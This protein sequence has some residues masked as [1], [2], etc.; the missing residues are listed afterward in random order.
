MPT[1]PTEARTDTVTTL[2][3]EHPVRGRAPLLLNHEQWA[4]K[5]ALEYM[6]STVKANFA[7][8]DD[9]L[10][11]RYITLQRKAVAALQAVETENTR[12]RDT[13][14]AT[15]LSALKRELKTLTG[16]DI[17]PESAR[18][19]TRYRA[20]KEGR[21]PLDVLTGTV[22]PEPKLSLNPTRVPRALDESQYVDS[23]HS[24]TLWDAACANFGYATDSVLLKPFS[25]EQASFI[26]YGE[27]A[28]EH[29]V[30]PY[31]AIVRRLDIGSALARTLSTE[32]GDTGTLKGLVR[33]ASRANFEFEL[34]EAHRNAAVSGIDRAAYELLL[35]VLKHEISA[36]IRPMMMLREPRAIIPSSIATPLLFIKLWNDE[37]TYSYFPQRLGGA[38]R[39]H[40]DGRDALPHFKQ[41]L[42]EDQRKKQ[43]GW[44]AR[45]WPLHELAHFQK[46]LTEEPRPKGLNPLAGLL[47][48]GFHAAFP[49]PSLENLTF[50][51]QPPENGRPTL[52]D[53]LAERQQSR[54]LANLSHLATT[55]SAADW[56][57]F[58]DQASAIGNEV[59]SMLTT[60][61]PGGVMGLNRIMQVAIFGS[62]AYSV[63]QGV[64]EAS[65]GDA[66]NFAGA[67]AD[68]V[69][70][71]ISGFLVGRASKIHRQRMHTL[72]NRT[73]KLRKV[74]R[75]DGAPELWAPDL[76]VYPRLEA[77]AMAGLTPT[78]DG[79]YERDG[80]YFA[81]V[82]DGETLRVLE[83]IQD[84]A[85]RG[86][87]LKPREAGAFAAPVTFDRA[88]STWRLA[89]DDVRGLSDVQL[90]DR[91]LAVD[92]P[93]QSPADLKRVL[94]ITGTTREQ[95]QN[96]WHGELI[97]GPLADG[98]RRLQTDR[99][100]DQ[101][102]SDVPLRG[103]MPLNADGAV[104]ALLTRLESWPAATVLDVYNPQGELTHTYGPDY[105]P[106]VMVNRV[107]LKRLEHGGYVA[108]DDVTQ[109]EGGAEQMFSLI[110]KQQPAGSR[111]G[112]TS[113]RVLS[114]TGRIA[115]VREHIADLAKTDRGLLFKALTALDGHTRNDPVASADPAKQYLPLSCPSI[116]DST[117]PLLA[118]LHEINPSLS[119]E[120]L[121]P[122]LAAH[123]F[124]PYQVTRAMGPDNAQPLAFAS[125]VDQL[126]IKLRVD[127]ALDGIYHTRAYGRDADHWALE[128]ARGVFHDTLQRDLVVT[129]ESTAAPGHYYDPK[130]P[131]DTT[132]E[133]V[134]YGSGKY[135]SRNFQNGSLEG[136]GLGPDQ[137]YQSINARLQPRERTR[138]GMKD[139]TDIAALRQ[140]VGDAMLA[141]RQPDGLVNLWDTSNGQYERD[142]TL[143]HNKTPGELGLYEVGGYLYVTLYGAVYQVQF[144]ATRHK[145]R[146]KHPDKV[147]V[148]TPTLEHNGDG[149]WRQSS[150]NPLDWG[151]IQLL[152]R[153]RAERVTVSEKMGQQ[154]MAVS[155]AD[156]GVLRQVHANN[157]KPPPILMDTWSR[158]EIESEIQHFVTR[159]QAHHTLPYANGDLQL[160][161][162][163]SVPGWPRGKVLKVVDQ[164]GTTMKEYGPD[165][166]AGL[167]RISLSIDQVR[168]GKFLH[169]VLTRMNEAE[170]R[171]LLGD[172]DPSIEVRVLGLAKKLAANALKREAN[173]FKAMYERAQSTS[174]PHVLLVQKQYSEMPRRVIE[175]LL[176]YTTAHEQ[177]HFLD[178]GLIP[179]RMS[180]Q[181][182]WTAREVRLA[183][184]YEGLYLDAAASPDS[185]KMTLHLLPALAGWPG[186]ISIEV[187]RH[188]VNGPVI[189]RV[190]PEQGVNTRVLVK[191]DNRYRAYSQQG[192]ALN[193]ESTTHNNLLSSILH[194]LSEA[195]RVAIA[196]A[197]VGDTA[198]LAE[199]IR[200]QA[201]KQRSTMRNLLALQAPAPWKKP[202]MRVDSSFIAY[203]LVV[204]YQHSV[205]SLDLVRQVRRLYPALS[206]DG[207]IRFLDELGG[208]E[209]SRSQE[210]ATR[211]VQFETLQAELTRWE[212]NTTY[213][214]TA[215]NTAASSAVHRHFVRFNIES[216]WRRETPVIADDHGVPLGHLLDLSFQ[217]VGDLPAL[218][219]DFSHV[220][221]V[222]MTGMNLHS[223]SEAFLSRFTGLRRLFMTQNHLTSLPVA[224][225]TMA[226]LNV[227]GLSG[228]QIALTPESVQRLAG[229]VQL[230]A[231]FMDN[232]PLGLAPDVTGM[233][234]LRELRL[235]N[236]GISEWP[237]GLTGLNRVSTVDLRSNQIRT[238]PQAVFNA[239]EPA[240]TNRGTW[241]QGNP[242][243]AQSHR[244]L[245]E[246]RLRTHINMGIMPVRVH[247]STAELRQQHQRLTAIDPWLSRTLTPGQ[248][249]LKLEQW[250]MIGQLGS[251]ALH[252]KVMLK[253]LA[254]AQRTMSEPEQARLKERVW[255]MI[256]SVL[257]DTTL[258]EKLMKTEYE[259]TCED[260]VMVQFVDRE[261]MVL[262]HEFEQRT[263]A[264]QRE[265]DYF[266]F[267][268]M[269]FRLKQ[270][271]LQ[272]Q[273]AIADLY[274]QRLQELD[275][276]SADEGV[277]GGEALPSV[278]GY[279]VALHYRVRLADSLELP[280]YTEK[281]LY[282]SEV[283]LT[284]ADV[285]R[286]KALIIEKESLPEFR[287]SLSRQPFWLDYLKTRFADQFEAIEAKY[288]QD[289]L[290]LSEEVG[291]TEEVELQRG[292]QLTQDRDQRIQLLIE[293]LTQQA[294]HAAQGQAMDVT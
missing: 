281:P 289:Y 133:L 294:Q 223:G 53:C 156:E 164:Y 255:S 230:N 141:R 38:V 2:P 8:L 195:E 58:K 200:E 203:P 242:L 114:D 75:E 95:L 162:L 288:Q 32:M 128:F 1:R 26:R 65:K 23:L 45:Q 251:E 154:I 112:Q 210:L 44:F 101:I 16:F 243:S 207:I 181:F 201:I 9:E 269:L 72:W 134:S 185:E 250:N 77:E 17:D 179:P 233:T 130:G 6:A 60:P 35:S 124:T 271:D 55:R 13:F 232:N 144:D 4:Q 257:A 261:L 21:S 247:E 93:T 172:Y 161:L 188:D 258:R 79:V 224:I 76:S 70:M 280:I 198:T 97:P 175:H 256:G 236:A 277:G 123:P 225:A 139:D 158:F 136:P 178:Q 174:R 264:S 88:S 39:Y 92:R 85:G 165:L 5:E 96:T 282:A 268:R 54:Y 167:A 73:G 193:L 176:D 270:V 18:I 285:A 109:G 37:G 49:E 221:V 64:I 34:L 132:V 205:H 131:D 12:I 43:L 222:N 211:R 78:A 33:E 266:S 137:L 231:L 197:D 22:E 46:L 245:S 135:K 215:G 81:K 168:S 84:S 204:E 199:K 147:G 74:T 276:Q 105:S 212:I 48:D 216:A 36:D 94:D 63:V 52:V 182:T 190:G 82:Q 41:Q 27:P 146:L 278:D 262:T 86:F 229:C 267:A 239:P 117:A 192:V 11:K 177:T 152:R 184:A 291:L 191:H 208:T 155:N 287:F 157:L 150:E 116:A 183:R 111:L 121:E 103:Q 273:A 68:V 293:E 180:E 189:D 40:R 186:G 260:G 15:H 219:G 153:L 129:D 284:D 235:H 173:L 67:I 286:I 100:I 220:G 56:Q 170:T 104:L 126:S 71:L 187:R 20:Y 259:A 283:E 89:L 102:I 99:L 202:P 61:M 120:S 138:L 3:P 98:V 10:K 263:R 151:G 246:Y 217:S 237:V 118:K 125:A 252:F 62:L 159:M 106:G 272:A 248:L 122:L 140:Q 274:N 42:I 66:S 30:G 19:Y 290:A 206:Y 127:L 171:V 241:L 163:Q 196:I 194:S 249:T 14:K 91:M 226:N 149:A 31:V 275:T 90:L 51:R 169:H 7:G 254:G 209:A 214:T 213:P 227:L 228:N 292:E 279:E 145:W 113:G 119:I 28:G 160:L 234:H 47:Y 25:Y 87:K 265:S 115:L 142:K 69:D 110:F 240:T 57:A 218:T 253:E 59:L 80:K 107:E 50:Y 148:N 166:S 143:I 108:K 83:L 24:I 238:I 244:L 29:P